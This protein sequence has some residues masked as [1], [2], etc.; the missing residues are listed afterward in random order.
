MSVFELRD[1]KYVYQSQYQRVEAL[2][3][4]SCAFEPGRV[5]AVMGRSGS[6]KTTLLSLMAGLDVPTEGSVLCEGVSTA[7]IDLE[8]YRRERV[9]VIYQDFRLFPL[10]TAAENVMYPMELRGMKPAAAKKRAAELI[11]KVGLPETALDRFPAMLSGGEQQR[12]AIARAL[13]MD[14]KVLLADE[15]TGNLDSKN[16][17]SIYG[18]LDSLAHEDGY[19]VVIVTHDEELGKRADEI[20]RLHDG[21]LLGSEALVKLSPAFKDYL[22]GGT[23]LRER[24]GKRCELDTVAESWELSAHPAGCCTVASGRYEGL[25]FP[26]YLDAVG[27]SVLGRNCGG[28][29]PLLI[30]FIDAK[31]RLSVQ[32]HPDDG[33]ALARENEPGKNE[34]WYVVDAEPGAELC[35]GFNRT[36]DRDE[37]RRRIE[38]HS[39]PEILHFCPVK[40][41]DLFFIPAGTVHALGAGILLCEIQQ[42]SDCTY[43]LYDYDRRDKAGRSRPL[44]VE[45]ALDVLNYAAYEPAALPSE[46][47]TVRCPYFEV[48]VLEV[49]GEAKLALSDESFRAAV[50][51]KGSGELSLAGTRL[52]IRAGMTVFIPA[53]N[54]TLRISGELTLLVARV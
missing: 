19:C 12:V 15:P 32:V 41:G 17:E 25:R 5:Y 48:R 23:R 3:G 27:R 34:L 52:E 11:A 7:E 9:A 50:C 26:Q 4:V 22:W 24:F 16:S 14:T 40:P 29:L 36:V 49:S 35:V 21:E 46:D 54:D 8:R 47:G 2:R 10:L 30:K 37:V 31:G 51:V 33:Y 20:L 28:E 44:H 42:S 6:G 18:I 1:V 13:G 43:R 38:D 53:A 39:L 45:K